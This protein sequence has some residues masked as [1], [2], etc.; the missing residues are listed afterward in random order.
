MIQKMKQKIKFFFIALCFCHSTQAQQFQTTLKSDGNTVEIYIRPDV[1]GSVSFSSIEFFI[2]YTSTQTLAFSNFQANTTHFPNITFGDND[3]TPALREPG[4]NS[5]YIA[6]LPSPITTTSREYTSGQE[7]KVCS[8]TVRGPA[9]TARLQIVHEAT[10]FNPYYL[11]LSKVIGG[12]DVD[13]A[14][15]AASAY[16]YPNTNSINSAAGSF[17]YYQP[18]MDVVL[19]LTLRDFTAKAVNQTALL[20][21][22]TT[23]ERNVSHFEIERSADTKQW[24]KIGIQKANAIAGVNATEDYH[25]DDKKAFEKTNIPYYRLKMVDNDGSFSYSPI[26]Q[27]EGKKSNILKIYPNP[28]KT[29]LNVES[30]VDKEAGQIVDIFG[31]VYATFTGPQVLDLTNYTEGVYFIKL[32]NGYAIR[33]VVT[34]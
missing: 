6:F 25:F 34:K 20:T 32:A 27:V 5:I 24:E 21:W 14:P 1:T 17:Y 19:P 22:Q 10:N 16:F 13:A 9:A 12:A 31:R 8:F 28:A 7:Y 4:Y 33:F 29:I 30:I 18:A 2:R 23:D 26:R 11:T 15:A 3:L